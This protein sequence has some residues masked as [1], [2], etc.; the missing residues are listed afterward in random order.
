VTVIVLAWTQWTTVLAIASVS[1]GT[2]ANGVLM[3]V[4]RGGDVTLGTLVTLDTVAW[5]DID[6]AVETITGVALAT[7]ALVVVLVGDDGVWN[8]IGI[9]TAVVVGTR[10]DF[11]TDL[12]IAIVASLTLACVVDFIS[13]E[14]RGTN[15]ILVATAIVRLAWIVGQTLGTRVTSLTLACV[16][17]AVLAGN[18]VGILVADVVARA[19]VNDFAS[20]VSV[21]DV[22]FV[23]DAIVSLCLVNACGIFV[24]FV[25]AFFA[26]VDGADESVVITREPMLPLGIVL[27]RALTE[28]MGDEGLDLGIQ[29][30]GGLNIVEVDQVAWD[31]AGLGIAFRAVTFGTGSGIVSRRF[32]IL[33]V[34]NLAQVEQLVQEQSKLRVGILL[35]ADLG[36]RGKESRA[37]RFP[38]DL[39]VFE[40]AETGIGL[41]IITSVTSLTAIIAT[42]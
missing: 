23:A 15:G 11:F 33:F 19:V 40:R 7:F 4:L 37:D 10:V 22:V 16:A 2:L 41:A 1:L 28:D 32:V 21:T 27:G 18:A 30:G 25:C 6:L 31:G 3:A 13:N 17:D 12:A 35:V 39:A 20:L 24:A 26:L 36:A 38:A 9:V 34:V 42:V 29:I 14:S 8:A 5:R